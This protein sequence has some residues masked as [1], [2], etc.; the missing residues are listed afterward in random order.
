MIATTAQALAGTDDIAA[1]TA[2]KTKQALDQKLSFTPIQQGGGISQGPNKIKIGWGTDAKLRVTVDASNVGFLLRGNSS[3]NLPLEMAAQPATGIGTLGFFT[4]PAN[5]AIGTLVAG[6]LL[7]PACVRTTNG[8]NATAGVV[9][10]GSSVP[11]TWRCL[12]GVPNV[13]SEYTNVTLFMRV[14]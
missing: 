14:S 4:C 3:D 9:T 7:I 6:S 8:S 10:S 12:G 5:L 2:L 11:G 13:T 1:M